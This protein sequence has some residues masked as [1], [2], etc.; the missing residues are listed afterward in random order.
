MP[1]CRAFPAS[2]VTG[3]A[4]EVVAGRLAG[5]PVL[6]LAGR[7]HYYEHGDAAVMRPVIETLARL[8][9]EKLILTNAAGS[10]AADDAARLGDADHRPH[11]FLR[12]QS[13]DRRADA[14]AASSA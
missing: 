11:Q 1:S 4:G 3:H 13:A 14:T 7:A 2:G 9:I 12:R 10:L 5:A 8:G 6:M